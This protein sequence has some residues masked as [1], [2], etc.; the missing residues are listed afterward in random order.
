MALAIC[1]DQLYLLSGAFWLAFAA[2][3]T[4]SYNAEAAFLAN[5]TTAEEKAAAL[6][7]FEA[8]LG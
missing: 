2:T 4:P 6:A 5:A 3:L 7:S 1:P 8:S